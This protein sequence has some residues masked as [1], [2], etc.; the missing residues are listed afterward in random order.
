MALK[1]GRGVSVRGWWV[2]GTLLV[3]MSGR[4]GADAGPEPA[5]LSSPHPRYVASQAAAWSTTGLLG[6][7][8]GATDPGRGSVTIH[9]GWRRTLKE[10]PGLQLEYAIEVVP[11][12]L[13]IGTRVAEGWPLPHVATVY[14]AGLDPLGV[15]AHFG[16]GR[17]RPY[18]ALRTGFRVFAEPVPSPRGTRFNFSLDSGGG[19]E[20][21]LR[22]GRWVFAGV[23]LHHLSNGGLGEANPSLNLF[24]LRGGLTVRR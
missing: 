16:R 13:A 12:E 23:E 9:L 3:L 2:T 14:G 15:E 20:W 1:L 11:A 21:R 5:S 4:A 6:L 7:L 18:V 8:G 22:D 24:T 19:V 17:L 10:G